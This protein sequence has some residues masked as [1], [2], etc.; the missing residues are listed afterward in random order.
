[1]KKVMNIEEKQSY[2]ETQGFK[3]LWNFFLAMAETEEFNNQIKSIRKEFAI[4]IKGFFD[5]KEKDFWDKLDTNPDDRLKRVLEISRKIEKICDRFHFQFLFSEEIIENYLYYNE[6][7]Y[8]ILSDRYNLCYVTDLKE[9]RNKK[10]FE[11]DMFDNQEVYPI[12][13]GISPYA[14]LR[15]ILDFIRKTYKSKIKPLQEKYKSSASRV[16]KIKSRNKA[17]QDRNKY[18]Y[19][20]RCKP[21]KEIRGMLAKRKLFLDDGHIGKIISIEKKRRKD[22]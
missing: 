21:L 5:Y 9:N 6:K 19:K 10:I 12:S 11:V 8:N 22:V 7:N 16:G 2:F 15:D 13:L 20:N 3:K 17:K 14:S 1:M 18:I 4:P